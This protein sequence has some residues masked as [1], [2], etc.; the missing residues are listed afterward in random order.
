M[1]FGLNPSREHAR[2]N[3]FGR[4][5]DADEAEA[6]GLAHEPD[7]NARARLL[8]HAAGRDR[9]PRR[10]WH[11]SYVGFASFCATEINRPTGHRFPA[12]FQN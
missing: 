1:R 3:F 8:R 12:H 5:V 4:E 6:R 10:L 11:V 2:G 9:R 7:A